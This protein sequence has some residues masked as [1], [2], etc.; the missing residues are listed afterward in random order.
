MNIIKKLTFGLLFILSLSVVSP[1]SAAVLPTFT[2]TPATS[3]ANTSA[4]LN[5]FFNANGAASTNMRFEIGKTP[6]LELTPT[7]YVTNTASSGNFNATITGLTPDTD[8]FFRAMGVTSAGIGFAASTLTFHTPAYSLPTVVTTPATNI[9]QTSATINGFFNANGYDTNTWFIY[10]T[11]ST[12]SSPITTS[13]VDQGTTSGIYKVDITG[14]SPSTT[15]YFRAAASNLGGTKKADSTLSFTTLPLATASCVISSFNASPSTVSSGNSTTLTWNTSNCTNLNIN[16]GIGAVSP[17]ASGSVTTSALTSTTTF[18][19][20]ASDLASALSPTIHTSQTTAT[21]SGGS[22]TTCTINS[23]SSASM[24]ISYG[25]TTT[26]TWN[27]NGC[28]TVSINNGIGAVSTS[29]Y[30]S[31]PALY[32][33]TVFTLTA[34]DYSGNSNTQQ[35]AIGVTIGTGGS[36]CSISNFSSGLSN[37]TSGGN[38]YITW[39]TT[40]C[41]YTTLTSS[42]GVFY[43]QTESVNGSI[44][45]GT[46]YATT[47][48]TLYAFG[49][50]SIN[51]S[52]VVSVNSGSYSYNYACSD[53]VDNDGDGLIDYPN[54]PGCTSPYDNDE[55]NAPTYQYQ[56]TYQTTNTG[57]EVLMTTSPTNV[58]SRSANFNAVVNNAYTSFMLYFN[59]G[60]S[61]DNLNQTT[62]TR[63]IYPTSPLYVAT[64]TVQL[65]PSTTYYYRAVGQ[66]GNNRMVYGNIMSFT[67]DVG[68]N[69]DV[70]YQDYLTQLGNNSDTT[71]GT[72]PTIKDVTLSVKNQGDIVHVNDTLEYQ[73]D[74]ANNT[75]SDVKNANIN[76]VLPQGFF[77]KQTTQGIMINPTTVN[78]P[79]NALLSGQ[80]GTIY[81]QATVDKSVATNETLVTNGTLSY[82]L[83]NGHHDSVVGYML[84]HAESS[85]VL[86]GL[87]FGT[88]FFP[89][90]I[91]GWFITIIIILIIILIARRIANSNNSA[92]G[93]HH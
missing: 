61:P 83:S 47:T 36:T 37:V 65:S 56:N 77:V 43:G 9:T 19:L 20:T 57:S 62:T 80:K 22:S 69:S 1:V 92:H 48:F 74:Y 90:T 3:V 21:V 16:N 17:S 8:Y 89:T 34:T 41:T 84:N 79:L 60:T 42:N 85:T 78:V 5:G 14:L 51:Q 71:T 46:M 28:A 58:G 6:L 11:S 52:L 82:V 38:T 63:Y 39:N 68:S 24:N 81:I 13:Y 26:L 91:F 55:Y 88:G 93:E 27:T 15:Y 86:A 23:L 44:S 49:T 67:T 54:D 70:V 4:V 25:G 75:N 7:Q 40:G 50:N 31:T 73:I 12:L 33:S 72:D 29:G 76:I 2:T 18:T 32:T 30:T 53:G 87:T 35:I 59:Y 64:D 10:A 66:F 45:T